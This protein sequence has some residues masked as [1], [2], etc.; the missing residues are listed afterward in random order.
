MTSFGTHETYARDDKVKGSSD[1]MFGFVFTAVFAVI[2][3]WPLVGGEPVRIWSLI[4]AAVILVVALVRP[5]LLAPFNRAWTR[6]GLLLHKVV[7]PILM[8]IIF[9]VAVTPIGLIMRAMGKD[10]LRLQFDATARTYW[11]ERTPPGPEPET[12]KHQF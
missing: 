3:L 5:A 9:F 11:I 8:G 7:N 12:M 10:P 2:A 4:V 1:R 6:F